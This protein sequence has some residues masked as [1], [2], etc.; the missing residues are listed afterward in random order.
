MAFGQECKVPTD[1][2]VMLKAP[3]LQ[4]QDGLYYY[5][6]DSKAVIYG[7]ILKTSSQ[8]GKYE[9]ECHWDGKTRKVF[10][11]FDSVRIMPVPFFENFEFFNFGVEY[12][13]QTLIEEEREFLSYDHPLVNL[14]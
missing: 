5:D 1:S 4:P 11:E 2:I 9:I 10:V 6:Q 8:E 13:Y 12:R 14:N 3:V 7:K